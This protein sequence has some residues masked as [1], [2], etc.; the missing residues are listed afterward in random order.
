MEGL[1][2]ASNSGMLRF[3]RGL[4]F[5]IVSIPEDLTTKLIVKKLRATA[6]A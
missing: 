4:G 2:L 6:S 5:E 1:V 3:A